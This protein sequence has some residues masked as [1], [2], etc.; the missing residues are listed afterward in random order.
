MK[1]D[2]KTPQNTTRPRIDRPILVEGKYDRLG[3]L[4]TEYRSV[5]TQEAVIR[6]ILPF[7]P[8]KEKP[9]GGIL[10]EPD[11][12]TVFEKAVVEY[13]AGRITVAVREGFAC[14]I[15]ARRMAMDSAGKNAKEMNAFFTRVSKEREKKENVCRK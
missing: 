14:E 8:A 3:I 7:E 1:N 6:W 13:V 11:P 15:A 10:F 5:L 9:D 4:S 12:A 2:D